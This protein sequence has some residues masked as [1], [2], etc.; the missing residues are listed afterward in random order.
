V[1]LSGQ[2]KIE[3]MMHR[4]NDRHVLVVDTER[5]ILAHYV[6][7]ALA[8]TYQV[9]TAKNGVGNLIDSEM[10]PHGMH[11]IAE[12]IGADQPV[13]TIF[14]S[15]EPTGK[16]WQEGDIGENLI[17]SRILRLQG[18]VEGINKGPR[19]DSFE[20]YIYIH[21]TNCEDDIG[22]KNVSHGCILMTNED[23]VT[24]FDKVEEGCVVFIN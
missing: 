22:R 9:S 5:K 13:G 10:T 24:L 7:H 23:M 1:K 18:E 17:L 15:R 8:A 2:M 14:E 6:N 19:V 4:F 21:G 3:L 20:R 11:T 16:V 12:K